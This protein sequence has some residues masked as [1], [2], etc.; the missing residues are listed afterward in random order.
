MVTSRLEMK[1]QRGI[2]SGI[3]IAAFLVLALI[4]PAS[5]Y[6]ATLVS[7]GNI[8][9]VHNGDLVC[10]QINGLLEDD[11]VQLNV[12]STDLKTAGGTFS[13]DNFIMPF[14]YVNGSASTSLVGNNLNASGLRLVVAREDGV[15]ITQQN[16]TSSN[17][18]RIFLTHDIL[19]T[20]Y[21]ISIRGFPQ[22]ASGAIIDFSVRGPVTNANNPANLNFTI[23]NIQTGHLRIQVNDGTTNQL[24]T[25]LMI[26]TKAAKTNSIF[27]PSTG[28]WY[29]DYYLNGVYNKSFRYG[30][31]PF[32]DQIIRG[33]WDGDGKDG[34]AIFRPSTGYWYFDY[35]L[36]GVVDKSFRYGG[37]PFNDQIIK[38]DWDGDGKDGIAIFRP[39]T[40]YWY[41]DYNLDG[42]VDKFFRYGGSTDRIIVGDWDGDVK[43]G[44]AIFRPSTGYWY[45]DYNL[46]GV[47]D[48]SFRYGGSTDW[49]IAGDWDGNGTDGIAI[50]RPSTGYWYFDYT[51]D[52][53]V[54]KFFRYGGNPFNDQIIKGDWT[55]D[56]RDGIAIFRTSTGYWYFDYNLD[57]AID[58][59]FRYGGSTDQI[60]VGTW[61]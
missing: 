54:D 49:I 43:D 2:A 55:G 53:V 56:G 41:F 8:N 9:Y 28:F 42:V 27:R 14:G 51:L 37:D 24:D 3:L 31:D 44:I 12:S 11:I 50:F 29:F 35:N 32:N 48:K 18:Y 17:P 30:G 47:V 34:I 1:K 4:P 60:I 16:Q 20:S 40:G 59:F 25:T 58:K 22:N 57:G 7:P 10:I 19:K 15:T 21:N 61:V 13:M 5:A 6:T 36:D 26:T 52:G 45:F 46:D 23:S 39:S 38:G 33:D